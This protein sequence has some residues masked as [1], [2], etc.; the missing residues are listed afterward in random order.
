[1]KRISWGQVAHGAI[2]SAIQVE[3]A[4]DRYRSRMEVGE[5]VF[6]CVDSISDR[7]AI[8]RTVKDRSRFSTD[9]RML[10]ETIRV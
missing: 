8:W 10:G 1:M 9:G 5:A 6:C 3:V 7:S 4:N 2:W